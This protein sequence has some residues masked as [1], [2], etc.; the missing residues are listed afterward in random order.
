[1]IEFAD[2]TPKIK[3]EAAGMVSLGWFWSADLQQTE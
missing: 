2:C 3:N 1:L